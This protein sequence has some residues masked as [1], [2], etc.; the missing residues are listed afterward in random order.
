MNTV[1]PFQDCGHW[2]SS[3]VDMENDTLNSLHTQW[4]FTENLAAAGKTGLKF[5]IMSGIVVL[6][7]LII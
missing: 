4:D 5:F 6:K 3:A 7:R 1:Y 2:N